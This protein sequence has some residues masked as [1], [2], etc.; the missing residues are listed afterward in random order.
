[1]FRSLLSA[2]ALIGVL[3]A[4][5]PSFADPACSAAC[6]HARAAAPAMEQTA[7]PPP[8][9]AA[10]SDASAPVSAG[11]GKDIVAVGFGWG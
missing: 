1:M 10:T 2:V 11:L 8:A 4:A 7:S 3:A 6:D 5:H 9:T